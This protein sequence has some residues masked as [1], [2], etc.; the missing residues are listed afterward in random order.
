MSPV[1]GSPG[2]RLRGA[3]GLAPIV[4]VT[5]TCGRVYQVAGSA[6][7][8]AQCPNKKCRRDTRT[9]PALP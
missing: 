9:L 2:R 6:V 7:D 5:C 1:G 4:D 3:P 8:L